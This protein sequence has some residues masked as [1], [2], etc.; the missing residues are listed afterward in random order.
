MAKNEVNTVPA[1][2]TDPMKEF[3]QVRLPRATGREED[4]LFVSL[5]GK[6]YNIKRGTTVRLPKPVY[7]ILVERE[8]QIDRQAAYDAQLQQQAADRAR[9]YGLA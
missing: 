2:P 9:Q 1:E 5:N 6:G 4:T 8:R 7:A 3:V